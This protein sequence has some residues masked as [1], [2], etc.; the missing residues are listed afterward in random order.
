MVYEPQRN[1]TIQHKLILDEWKV[2]ENTFHCSKQCH[3]LVHTTFLQQ[4]ANND[5]ND[6]KNHNNEK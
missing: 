2:N 3:N 1:E 6:K 5:D 4:N